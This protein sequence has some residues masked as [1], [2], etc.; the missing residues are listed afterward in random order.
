M[1]GGYMGKV[2]E[3]DLNSKQVKK[4][5][6]PHHMLE[7]YVGNKGLGARLLYDL[8]PPATDPLSE[9][10]VF[11]VTTAPLTGS[12]APSSN[13]F[14]ITTKSPLT[15]TIVNSNCGGDFGIHLKKAGYD[16]LIITG[17]ADRPVY[18]NID[19]ENVSIEDAAELWGLDTQK[20]QEKLPPKTGKIVI[21][22]AGE[23]LVKYASVISEE[24][25][26]GR[27]GVGAVMG[28]KNLK[29]VVARGD[30]KVRVAHEEKFKE[31]CKKWRELARQ[32]PAT[33]EEL[34]R[35]GTA[36]FVNKC[37]AT[38]TLPTRNYRYGTFS[39]AD[40]VSGETLAEKY[41]VKN[42]GCRGCPIAC[43]RLVEFKGKK[44]KGP[45]Y[46][47]VGLLG[48]NIMNADLM[49]IIEFNYL[50]DLLGLDTISLGNTL[51][52]VM[53]AG[54]KGLIKTNLAFG[55]IDGISQ[56]IEDIAYRRGFGD[57]MAEGV[58]YLSQKYGGEE[59]AIHV[60]GLEIASYE[61]RG[62]VG[63][64]LGYA[65]ASRGGCHIGGG[66][67][68]YLEANGP[69]T[70]DPLT[71]LGKPGLVVLNQTTMEAVSSLGCCI[72]TVYMF[73]PRQL[74]E[75]NARSPFASKL[76]RGTFL[77]G[78]NLIG[79]ALSLPAWTLPVKPP[80]IMLPQVWAHVYC[81]GQRFTLGRL[82][83][84]GKRVVNMDRIFNLREGLT[85]RDDTL[86]ARL[87]EELQR[88]EEPNSRVPLDKM[89]PKY[90]HFRG[91]SR[92]GVPKAKTLRTLRIDP[93]QSHPAAAVSSESATTGS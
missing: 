59:F 62:A 65:I 12:G 14:N 19:G 37:N 50:A 68:I 85:A 47:T 73:L 6:L 55:K 67:A 60:K 74:L 76:I 31:I 63:Q 53:E 23:N 89:L 71:P 70:V 57:E 49:A 78:G 7:L 44:I 42:I 3:V 10:N 46:E 1:I 5:A 21:G 54:E 84:L 15:G 52:F 26:A 83:E 4:Y 91:W 35:Y 29:A 24:R 27:G 64:G 36:V 56:A 82:M 61:P 80:F 28:S 38:F 18:L 17:K 11:I 41:L 92:D 40:A 34:P 20:T 45:E 43:G 72:F 30:Q 87:T 39:E 88:S 32:H 22:P 2:L 69:I 13:R 93:Q 77:Y 81:T 48:P 66:Y 75:L 9:K 79:R 58:R 25:V 16:A 90:Y 33:G 86:P 51:G 8:L